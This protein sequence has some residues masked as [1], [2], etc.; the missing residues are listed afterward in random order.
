MEYYSAFPIPKLDGTPFGDTAVT[1]WIT[2]NANYTQWT[3]N[4]KPGLKWSDGTNVTAQDILSTFSSSFALNSTYDFPNLE[5]E[6]KNGYALNSSAA[7]FVLNQTDS[8]WAEKI[9]WMYFSPVYPASLIRSQGPS[10]SNLGTNVVDGPFYAY[11]YSAGQFQM[12]MLRNSYYK[13]QPQVCEID[14]NFVDSLAETATNLEA[15]TTDL[16][17]VELSNALA[18][19]KNPNLHLSFINASGVQSLEYNVT[20][21]PYNMTAF[22]QALLYGIDENQVVS[23]ALNGLGQIAYSAEGIVPPEASAWYNPNIKNYSF[24]QTMATNLLSSIGITKGSDGF[25]HYPNGSDVSL[26]LWADTDNPADVIASSIVQSDLQNLGLK[27]S[28][29]TTSESNII[30]DFASNVGDIARTGM[31]LFSPGVPIFGDAWLT[32]QPGWL[33]YFAPTVAN[34]NW[35]YPPS[36][37]AQYQANLSG[38]ISTADPN[39]LKGYLNNVQAINA[40]YLPTIILA[41]PDSVLAY[42][43]QHWTNWPA[44]IQ[45][46][47]EFLNMT[48]FAYLQPNSGT[49]STTPA[50]STTSTT[51]TNSSQT[52]SQT[53]TSSSTSSA[54][55]GLGSTELIGIAV[56][57]VVI[58]VVVVSVLVIRRRS[59]PK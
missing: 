27:I 1:D 3:L 7:V 17:P 53:I 12:R 41:Y 58:V 10:T 24:D 8:H 43:T 31:I 37:D 6:L 46:E 35:E 57:V 4:V 14:V 54:T 28:P 39:L 29:V 50:T 45:F 20:V 36:V 18:V 40:Q 21:Y 32:A 42:S 22:R 56:G 16:A 23:K 9:S 2:H 5:A 47:S 51:S 38:I 19:L 48:A 55:G 59:T 52:S 30:G 26:S 49:T 44:G 11:N 25:M 34:I 15:G 13:P 33:T